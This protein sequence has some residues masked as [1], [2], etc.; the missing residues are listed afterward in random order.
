[1]RKARRPDFIELTE[2]VTVIG[3]QTQTQLLFARLLPSSILSFLIKRVPIIRYA[4]IVF[5]ILSSV[6]HS[7]IYCLTN[8]GTPNKFK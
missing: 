4:N 2:I 6:S 3:V 7:S 1:M 8:Y 5:S